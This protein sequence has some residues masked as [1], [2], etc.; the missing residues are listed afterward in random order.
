MTLSDL[1]R[2]FPNEDAAKAHLFKLRYRTGK[3]ACPRCKSTEK[4]SRRGARPGEAVS[5]RW[6]C[7]ACN[8]NGYGFSLTTGTVF[9]E[10]KLP[11]DKW[12]QILFLMLSAKKG[13]SALQIQRQVFG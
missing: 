10:T 12:F 9:E 2:R 6:T 1:I 8:R 4:I 11:L 13:T 7:K 5:Y 3:V